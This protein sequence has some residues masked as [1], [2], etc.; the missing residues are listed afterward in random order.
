MLAHYGVGAEGELA[1]VRGT[2]AAE[3]PDIEALRAKYQASTT[4]VRCRASDWL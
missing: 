4:V 2:P 1:R 3:G